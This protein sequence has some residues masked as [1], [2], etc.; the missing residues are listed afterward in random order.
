MSADMLRHCDLN[1]L[2]RPSNDRRIV[3]V[4][5]ALLT[6]GLVTHLLQR[7]YTGTTR[8]RTG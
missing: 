8:R 3:V 7:D 4:T 6:Y 5:T 2:D 1:N